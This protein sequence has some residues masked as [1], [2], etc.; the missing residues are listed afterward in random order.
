MRS[1]WLLLATLVPAPAVAQTLQAPAMGDMRA[2]D[3]GLEPMMRVSAADYAALARDHDAFEVAAARIA[4]A[5]AQTPTVRA[6]ATRLATEH[7]AA[8]SGRTPG[9]AVT[10]RMRMSYA[11]ALDALRTAPAGG[12]DALYLNQVTDAHRHAWALHAGF[13]ADGADARLK[14]RA[15]TDLARTEAHLHP[16]PMQPM[17]Y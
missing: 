6:L 2:T 17:R 13:A 1:T 10:P 15:P 4:A 5:R 3:V 7:G 12:F 9:G 16:L 14:A 8:L 11:R